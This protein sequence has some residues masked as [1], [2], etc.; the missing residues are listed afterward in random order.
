MILGKG[1]YFKGTFLTLNMD[2]FILRHG[3]ADKSSDTDDSARSLTV[4]G[5]RDVTHVARWLKGLDMKFDVIITS[6][7]KRANQTASIVAKILNIENKLMDWDELQPESNR[8]ALYHKLSSEQFEKK[9]TVLIVGHE[10]YLSTLISQ[11][12][13]V[14]DDPSSRIVLK[15][16]GLAKMRITSHSAQIMHGELEWLLTPKLMKN[17]ENDK[18]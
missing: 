14:T 6:P 2:L 1:Y 9:S 11:V 13:S 10:P 12:T 3:E 8:I 16:A 15:K 5:T 17:I 4:A 18:R 7:L